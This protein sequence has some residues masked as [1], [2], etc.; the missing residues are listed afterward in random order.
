[1]VY[2][3]E[4]GPV[5]RE[6]QVRT[7]GMIMHLSQ[8]ANFL[9]PVA[10]IIIPIVIWQVKKNE[11]PELD[12]HGKIIVNWML[13]TLIYGVVCFLLVFALVGFVL[14]P[15]LAALGIIF[16]IIGGIKANNGEVW[17]YP[18]SIAFFR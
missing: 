10:G 13:G 2:E 8:L 7:W 14:L 5:D 16:P 15:V 1:M 18:L 9:L 11:L 12:I 4:Y 3:P 17:K 6:Q